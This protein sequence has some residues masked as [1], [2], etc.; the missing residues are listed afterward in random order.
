MAD[1]TNMN[2]AMG[3]D[4]SIENEGQEFILLDEGDYEFT[5]EK[6]ERGQFNGSAKLS[7]SPKATLTLAVATDRGTAH[8][9]T[10]LILNRALEWKLCQFFLSIGL[11][12]HGEPLVMKWGEVTGRTGKAH[13]RQRS[14]TGNDGVERKS[15][16]VERYL[17]PMEHSACSSASAPAQKKQVPIQEPDMSDNDEDFLK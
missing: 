3:W 8:V 12:K 10:D 9:K 7:P 5:V 13:I 15:N 1:N 11:K 4:D 6:M 17:D 2:E 14:W 16:D